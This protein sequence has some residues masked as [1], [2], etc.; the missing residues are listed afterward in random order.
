ML[1]E[2]TSQFTANGDVYYHWE[3]WDGPDGIDHATGFGV[4][5]P[6]VFRKVTEW[7][8]KIAESYREADDPV[9]LGDPSDKIN[10]NSSE[11]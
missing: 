6:T 3:L 8:Q 4:D 9:Y 11:Q 1:L 7:R 2:V 10:R 5:L